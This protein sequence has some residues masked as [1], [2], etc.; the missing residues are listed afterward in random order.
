MLNPKGTYLSVE[1]EQ[2]NLCVVFTY[3][4]KQVREIRR[5]H[6]VVVRR[7]LRN[8]QKGVMHVQ[9]CSC[10]FANLHPFFLVFLLPSSL[11]LLKL[12]LVAVQ[13]LCYHGNVMSHFSSLLGMS[14]IWFIQ[15]RYNN[16]I[17]IIID[18]YIIVTLPKLTGPF[19]G[20][21]LLC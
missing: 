10:C 19:L 20:F 6:V 8:V 4:I 17:I 14:V 18:N 7:R 5:F 9:L 3:S 21:C 12:P 2:E 15:L 1:K 13:K 11:L 16:N